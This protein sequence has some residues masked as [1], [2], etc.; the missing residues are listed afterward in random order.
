MPYRPRPD[1]M[2]S[3]KDAEQHH[4]MGR[5]HAE[6]G[7][8]V[9]TARWLACDEA[10]WALQSPKDKTKKTKVKAQQMT[11]ASREDGPAPAAFT[12]EDNKMTGPEFP[13]L[14]RGQDDEPSAPCTGSEFGPMGPSP[15]RR[16]GFM[17]RGS[18]LRGLCIRSRRLDLCYAQNAEVH[19]FRLAITDFVNEHKVEDWVFSTCRNT[20]RKG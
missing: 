7:Q 19:K 6:Q 1:N 4:P 8:C 12:H 18:D 20:I 11:K 9:L 17:G 2:L 16:Q 15:G 10:A 5:R 3:S 13:A 14:K